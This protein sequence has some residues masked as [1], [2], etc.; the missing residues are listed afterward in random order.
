M[1]EKIALFGPAGNSESFTKAGYKSSVDA[2]KYLYERGL[3]TYEYQCGRGVLLGE[4][5]AKKIG[6]AA[7]EYNIELS[8][9]APYYMNLSNHT[10]LGKLGNHYDQLLQL[11]YIPYQ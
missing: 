4:E 7:K 5:T 3:D 10:L 2:P 1:E 9:H 6:D 8:I 11:P